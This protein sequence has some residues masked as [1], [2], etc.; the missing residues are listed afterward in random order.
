MAQ[1]YHKEPFV[2]NTIAFVLVPL[3]HQ[4]QAYI[5]QMGHDVTAAQ[6]RKSFRGTLL[7]ELTDEELQVL[8]DEYG[9]INKRVASPG[10]IARAYT[11]AR[12]GVKDE[13]IKTYLKRTQKPK[14]P[15]IP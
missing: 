7:A 6:L 2:T 13:T 10:G 1:A 12:I 4:A 9:E 14:S 8:I 15:T 3:I 11:R 5:R